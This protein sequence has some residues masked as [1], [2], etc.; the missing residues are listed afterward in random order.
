ME[1]FSDATDL[2]QGSTKHV[3][4]S[5]VVPILLSLN[6][7]LNQLLIRVKYHVAL[8]HE[9]LR[10]LFNRFSGIMEQL[11]IVLSKTVSSNSSSKTRNLHFDSNIFLLSCSID[12]QHAYHWLQLHPGSAAVK[13]ALKIK[14]F[15]MELLLYHFLCYLLHLHF[16]KTNCMQI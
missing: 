9:L 8:V 13:E 5:C 11:Q 4:V 3:T 1:P 16:P 14:I 10:S 15:G 7:K 2:A 6:K 12:P